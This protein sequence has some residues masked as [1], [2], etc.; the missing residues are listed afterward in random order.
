MT[1]QNATTATSVTPAAD[2]AVT[3][4]MP[5]FVGAIDE[6]EATKAGNKVKKDGKEAALIDGA[7]GAEIGRVPQ[8][9]SFKSRADVEKA[10]KEG[11]IKKPVKEGKA[12][13]PAVVGNLTAPSGGVT[14]QGTVEGDCGVSYLYMY[15][16]R[17]NDD[18]FE[19]STGFDLNRTAVD[20]SWQVDFRGPSGF[21]AQWKDR[22]PIRPRQYWTSGRR[23]EYT[24]A[25]GNHSG[26]V[27]Q[28]TAYVLN[29]I[30]CFTGHPEAAAYVS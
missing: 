30:V 20:F 18:A 9:Q 23:S 25:N 14:T 22:G 1:R 16:D 13:T 19:F 4:E 6:S 27:T 2:D 26:I 24:G 29:G 7:T 10:A 3:V 8:S 11:K 12:K 5:M 15:N 28:G 17:S 21:G